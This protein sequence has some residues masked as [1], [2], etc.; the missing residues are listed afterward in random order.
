MN[1]K[2][3]SSAFFIVS[4]L[5]FIFGMDIKSLPGEA[6]PNKPNLKAKIFCL[7]NHGCCWDPANPSTL[8]AVL[9]AFED[10]DVYIRNEGT[11]AS[12]PGKLKVRWFDLLTCS[13]KNAE[14]NVPAIL[15]GQDTVVTTGHTFYIA[16]KT[17]GIRIAVVYQDQ[18]NNQ[19]KYIRIVKNCPDHY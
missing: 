4:S 9:T 11:A 5:A 19:L 3:L 8:D 1:F 17:E 2:K 14:V 18:E 12:K 16:K 7:P 13:Y 10:P 15:P 6:P